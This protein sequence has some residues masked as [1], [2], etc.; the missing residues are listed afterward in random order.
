MTLKS[1]GIVLL[2]V[3]T[4]IVLYAMLF[5]D[6]SIEGSSYV[7]FGLLNQRLVFVIVGSLAILVGS[8]VF[9][10]DRI[11]GVG[12]NATAGDDATQRLNHAKVSGTEAQT[13]KPRT[14]LLPRGSLVVGIPGLLLL[15]TYLL[16][17]VDVNILGIP[18]LAFLL[19]GGAL[20][21]TVIRRSAFGGSS[22]P[23]VRKVGTGR[24]KMM[25]MQLIAAFGSMG[26]GL[27]VVLLSFLLALAEPP[28][29]SLAP[30][31][32]ACGLSAFLTGL[33]YLVVGP[34]VGWFVSRS[35][36]EQ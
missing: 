5:M 35:L 24:W 18:L 4:A 12:V 10:A 32:S 3:G 8:I 2:S 33:V 11:A 36:V 25:R 17:P 30:K 29:N 26:L 13:T 16:P 14:A 9:V 31:L 22:D 19:L 23:V 20:L 34:I 28:F 27:S 15:C 6:V 21:L 1:I 7:N